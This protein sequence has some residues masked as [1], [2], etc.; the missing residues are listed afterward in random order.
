VVLV[1]EAGRNCTCDLGITEPPLYLLSYGPEFL[2]AEP[3]ERFGK[4]PSPK[5]LGVLLLKAFGDSH[6]SQSDVFPNLEEK[7]GCIS[8]V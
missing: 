1:G 8:V 3:L 7:T 2:L 5:G 6:K 4:T